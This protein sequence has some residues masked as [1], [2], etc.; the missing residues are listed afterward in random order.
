M[1]A[2]FLWSGPVLKTSGAKVAWS[3]VCKLEDEGGLGIRVLKEVNMVYG[4]KIIW[5]LL[6]GESL[7]GRWIKTYLLKKKSFW[8]VSGKTQMGSW[9]WKK[10]LK[11]REIAKQFV[12]HKIGNGR[13][14]SFWFDNW[15]GKGVLYDLLGDRGI[16]DLGIRREATIEEATMRNRRRRNHRLEI[17]NSIEEEISGVKES[18][19]EDVE[20][21]TLW[22]SRSGYKATFLTKETWMLVRKAYAKCDWVKGAWFPMATLKFAFISWLAMRDRLSTMDRV[23]IW[24]LSVDTMCVLC[25]LAPE[26]RNH[27]FF[28]CVYSAQ[29]WEQLSLGILRSG[30]TTDWSIIVSLICA[31]DRG[32]KQS[33]CIRYAFQAAV[34]ALWRE[35]NKI[36]HGEEPMPIAT[37]KK[38]IDKGIR[39][40][41]YLIEKDRRKGMEGALQY[42]F[43]T[44]I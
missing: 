34:Y 12:K 33:F 44:R 32:R 3:D 29:V 17:L 20:D 19:R 36:R 15:S 42:W 35:R 24:S 16:I 1:C 9:M 38:I 11:L 5:R 10:I 23:S 4:L 37:L 6:S 43:E 41:L 8:A 18:L 21:L 14:V 31:S 26:S 7:W 2:S 22:K 30:Y 27:L 13:H 25:K 39:N 40:K 28:E